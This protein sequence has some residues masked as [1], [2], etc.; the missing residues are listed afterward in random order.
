M[1]NKKQLNVTMWVLTFILLFGFFITYKNL[2]GQRVLFDSQYEGLCVSIV[3][4]V[5]SVVVGVNSSGVES[6][7]YLYM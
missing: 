7:K 2:Q 4:L 5:L 1:L 6:F 3:A